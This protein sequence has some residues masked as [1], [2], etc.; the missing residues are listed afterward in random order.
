[1]MKAN[2]AHQPDLIRKLLKPAAYP[3]GVHGLQ[4]IETHISWVI[5]TGDY[6]YKVKKPVTLGF[7]DFSSLE[8]RRFFCEEELRVNR[9]TAPELYLDVVPIG[10]MDEKVRVGVEPAIEYA[11]RM[12]QFPHEARLDRYLQDDRMGPDDVRGTSTR[13]CSVTGRC[14]NWR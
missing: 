11:V 6:A 3:H 8:Q 2:R 5:L 9:R 12:R 13:P 1:M 4:V 10:V 14:S 7:L